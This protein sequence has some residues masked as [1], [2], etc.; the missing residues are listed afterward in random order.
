MGM[1]AVTQPGLLERDAG[2]DS[3]PRSR[4]RYLGLVLRRFL[5]P[6]FVVSLYGMLRWRVVISPRAEVELSGNLRFGPGNTVSSFSKIKA[7]DGVLQTGRGCGF[8]TGCFVDTGTGGIV[9]GNN[10]LCGPNV[11][12]VATNYN[13]DRVSVPLEEQGVHS[14]GIRI[15]NNCW[16]GA[17]SVVLD[18][19]EIGDNSIVAAGSIVNRRF[20]PNSIIQGNPA[21]LLL[22]RH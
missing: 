15:G 3:A 12:L 14:V 17:N 19:S 20:P 13:Y 9:M 1:G 5:V 22:R 21:K 4:L 11:V 10:V 7:T 8:G 16:I 2:A 6:G 18:G